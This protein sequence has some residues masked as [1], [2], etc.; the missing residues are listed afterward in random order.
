MN[1]VTSD[2]S[3]RDDQFRGRIMD[4]T[5]F[6]TATF[7][8]TEPISLGSVPGV[9]AT[10][11]ETVTGKL[12]LHGT[13][14]TVTFQLQARRTA[15]TIAVSGSIPIVFADYGV[16]NPSGGPATTSDRGTL[17]FLINLSHV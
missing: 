11:S 5:D 17:E 10:V 2:Q 14:K 13:T 4:T 15:S 16:N 8:L 1:T 7:A 9:G 6:P 12:T 3:Q